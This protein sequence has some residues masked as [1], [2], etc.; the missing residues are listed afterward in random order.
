[1]VYFAEASPFFRLN[2]AAVYDNSTAQSK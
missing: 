1:L 2:A